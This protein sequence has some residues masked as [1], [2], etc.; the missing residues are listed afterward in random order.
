MVRSNSRT[1]ELKW[2]NQNFTDQRVHNWLI[3][4]QTAIYDFIHKNDYQSLLKAVATAFILYKYYFRLLIY[5]E[6]TIKQFDS[7]FDRLLKEVKNAKR[8]K[9]KVTLNVDAFATTVDLVA[10]LSRIVQEGKYF[11]NISVDTKRFKD[12]LEE[13]EKLEG[14]KQ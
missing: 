8:E 13:L 11:F 1:S 5:D 3:E 12:I 14:D 4:H 2:T 7:I 6:E 10:N 9:D